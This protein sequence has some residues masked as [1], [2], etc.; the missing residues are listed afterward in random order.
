MSKRYHYKGWNVE[1]SERD[2]S[3]ILRYTAKA[4]RT[5]SVDYN[6]TETDIEIKVRGKNPENVEVRIKQL[7]SDYS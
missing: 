1:E 6:G 7:I 2:A 3:Y 5:M 4:W